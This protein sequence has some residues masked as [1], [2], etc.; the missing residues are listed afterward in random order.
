MQKRT[1]LSPNH[2]TRN[3]KPERNAGIV[4]GIRK[5]ARDLRYIT[6]SLFQKAGRISKTI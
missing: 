6:S 4:A 2:Y 5:R 1:G 3:S